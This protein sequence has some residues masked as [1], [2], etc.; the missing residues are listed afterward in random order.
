MQDLVDRE[1]RVIE[2]R[3][4]PTPVSRSFRSCFEVGHD[5]FGFTLVEL[6]VVIAIVGVV[7][8]LLLPAVQQSRETAR[9]MQCTNN[10][11][12]IGLALHNYHDSHKRFPPGYVTGFDSS[13]KEIGPGWGWATMILPEMEQAPVRDGIRFVDSIEHPSNASIR[14]KSIV[15][16]LCPSDSVQSPWNAVTR[17]SMG[18]PTTVICQVAASNYLGVFGVREPVGDGDGILF[19]NS[20]I[21]LR[22]ILDGTSSTLLIGERSHR[23]SEATWLGAVTDAELFPPKGSPALPFIEGASSMVLGHTFEGPPNAPNLEGNNF[24]SQHS[25]G[26][27]FVFADGHVQFVTSSTDKQVFRALSTRSG[28]E[29]LGDF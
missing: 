5:R 11:K 18:F 26:A 6:L 4:F 20:Q 14:I 24:S 27:N 12:Q 7:V 10:L 17:D 15:S 21:G 25:G 19:R 16:Y 29:T 9:R 23:W 1:S 22:D 3:G 28:G 13:G 2:E 8:G